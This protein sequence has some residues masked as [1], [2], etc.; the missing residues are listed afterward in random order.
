MLQQ[1]SVTPEDLATVGI[2]SQNV[3]VPSSTLEHISIFDIVT[4][5]ECSNPYVAPNHLHAPPE[6]AVDARITRPAGLR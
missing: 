3:V 1:R 2:A 4:L 6:V 5:R